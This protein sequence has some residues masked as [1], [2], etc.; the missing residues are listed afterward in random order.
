MPKCGQCGYTVAKSAKFCPNCGT[1]IE[2]SESDI[3]SMLDNLDLSFLEQSE[4][5]TEQKQTG[6]QAEKKTWSVPP[7]PSA[8]PA[9]RQKQTKTEPK[10]SSWWPATNRIQ[11]LCGSGACLWLSIVMTV[12]LI[13]QFP[14]L[15]LLNGY[16]ALPIIVKMLVN[17]PL[18]L[19][20]AGCWICYTGG[21]KNALTSTGLSLIEGVLTFLKWTGSLVF[22]AGMAFVILMTIEFVFRRGR[23]MFFG[24]SLF[25]IVL[26]AVI[27]W[28]NFRYWNELRGT[29]RDAKAVLQGKSGQQ[30]RRIKAGLYSAVLLIIS[31]I[32]TFLVQLSIQGLNVVARMSVYGAISYIDPD[33]LDII[34]QVL[35]WLPSVNLVGVF[36]EPLVSL[37]SAVILLKLRS[38]Q[39]EWV[40]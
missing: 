22:F 32:G 10:S 34:F 3:S 8:Q 31:A 18:I 15:P 21:R 6:A 11:D 2:S 4:K 16:F 14:L 40:G 20:C 19:I 1:K 30:G 17:L 25:L 5:K 35:E 36:A 12:M 9:P 33:T 37:L 23:Q 27:I 26:F 24:L 38:C 39:T 28:L 29:V 7:A 13:A